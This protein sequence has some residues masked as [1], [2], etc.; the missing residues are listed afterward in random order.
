MWRGRINCTS[1]IYRSV[2]ERTGTGIYLIY[3]ESL[4]FEQK[5]GGEFR[6]SALP[7][8]DVMKNSKKLDSSVPNF[9]LFLIRRIFVNR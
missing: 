3:C 1:E 4:K 5:R 2:P 8:S 9:L 7:L 6:L